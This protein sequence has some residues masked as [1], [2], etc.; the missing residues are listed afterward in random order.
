MMTDDSS[1]PAQAKSSPTQ[2]NP[3]LNHLE[4]LVGDWEM[5]VSH[6]SFLPSPSDTTKGPV[7]VEWVQGGAFLVMYMGNKPPSPPSAMWLIGR[8]ESTPNYTVLYY[9]ARSV[10]RIYA[11]SFSENVWKMWREAPGFWQRYEGTLSQNGKSIT[12]HWE[13][14]SDGTTW[15]RDF[16]VT[17]TRTS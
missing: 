13:K 15:E 3:A 7:T 6:A 4:I 9:D 8:D 12:A 1:I 17:Y 2:P 5:E 11:M 16:D 14:S 10:S